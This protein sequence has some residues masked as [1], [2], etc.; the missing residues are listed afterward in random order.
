MA[1]LLVRFLLSV[2]IILL[3]G[4]SHLFAHRHPTSAGASTTIKADYHSGRVCNNMYHSHEWCIVK[5][6]VPAAEKGREEVKATEID[7]ESEVSS[8]AC[9]R[10]VEITQ[11]CIAFFYAQLQGYIHS[12]HA[13]RLPDCQHLSY[14]VP[15]KCVLHN[16]FRI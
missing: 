2:S 11:Y 5:T 12:H 10:Q 15:G 9:K 3:G 13:R 6:A 1:K 8:S 4:Y 7:E 16:V 14:A